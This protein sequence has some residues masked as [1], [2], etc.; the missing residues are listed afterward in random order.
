MKPPRIRPGPRLPMGNLPATFEAA[1]TALV[2]ARAIADAREHV[3]ALK[4]PSA[5][6]APPTPW[7]AG[8][9]PPIGWFRR[10]DSRSA[11]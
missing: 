4:S 1:Q 11:G 3:R 6:T 8:E 5:L 7:S 9:E 10:E 2:E